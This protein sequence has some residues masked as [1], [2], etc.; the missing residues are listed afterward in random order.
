MAALPAGEWLFKIILE[1]RKRKSSNNGLMSDE[2]GI[3]HNIHVEEEHILIQRSCFC[4]F[5][6]EQQKHPRP[7]NGRAFN[8]TWCLF[9]EHLHNTGQNSVGQRVGMGGR[10]REPGTKI[11]KGGYLSLWAELTVERK[12]PGFRFRSKHRCQEHHKA[13]P[14]E[15]TINSY[16]GRGGGG[17]GAQ[18]GFW[19]F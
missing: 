5:I 18:K 6:S 13:E 9:C 10:V 7:P 11:D 2:P 3:E 12:K 15:W 17:G 1:A 4:T 16:S 14:F 19:N 8:L